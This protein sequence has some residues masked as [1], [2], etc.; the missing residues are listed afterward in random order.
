[1]SL[2]H[3]VVDF[4]FYGSYT[5]L[6]SVVEFENNNNKPN[7]FLNLFS[8]VEDFVDGE[9]SASILDDAKQFGFEPT[10][11]TEDIVDTQVQWI[12][13]FVNERCNGQRP[14]NFE[15][16]H[17]DVEKHLK[18]KHSDNSDIQAMDEYDFIEVKYLIEYIED[19]FTMEEYKIE[20]NRLYYQ[21]NKANPFAQILLQQ[22]N[23]K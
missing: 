13:Q 22:M 3:L 7:R 6:V 12:D 21:K 2:S 5:G 15:I 1:M 10:T 18:K 8:S 16:H 23:N 9:D 20:S 4:S 19:W 17:T 14:F 11:V